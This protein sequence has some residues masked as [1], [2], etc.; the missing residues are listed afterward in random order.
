[1]QGLSAG[2]TF[3]DRFTLVRRLGGGGMG[4]VWLAEDSELAEPVALK[5]LDPALSASTG[6]V[7]L[8]RQECSRARSLVHPNIVRVFDF[9]AADE[10]FFVSMQYVGGN[11]LIASRGAAFQTIVHQV[12]MVCDALAY[13][14]RAGVI[15][16]DV[17]ASNVLVDPNGVCYLTD[18]G[19]ATVISPDGGA[20]GGAPQGGGTLPSMSP[21]QLAGQPAAVADDVYSL[22][23]LLYELLSGA[24][25]FHP[26]VT[27]EKIRAAKPAA[28]AADQTG[29]P[30]PES[31]S[32]L[33][34]AMLAKSPEQ[35]PA[36]IG[37]VRSVLEDV[38]ADFPPASLVGQD[39]DADASDVIRPISRR[40]ATPAV[41]GTDTGAP[42]RR[43]VED[44]GR[45]LPPALVYGSLAALLAVALVVI[46]LLPTAVEERREAARETAAEEPLETPAETR[47]AE[48][49]PVALSVKREIADE[50]L[51]ELLVAEDRL[52]AIG[53]DVWGA[54][55]WA[56][57]ER[58]TA[59]GDE[60]Y[61]SR[62]YA[63]AVNQYRQALNVMKILEPRA[64]E[65]LATALTEGVAALEAGDRA[66]AEQ[67]FELALAI[68]PVNQVAK[69]GLDRA[70][71]LDEILELMRRAAEVEGSGD[72]AAAAEL[73]EQA[74]AVD[75]EWSAAREGLRR[76][77]AGVAQLGYETR[78]AAGFGALSREEFDRAR[79]EFEAALAIRPG[80]ADAA[81]ALR[82]V[83]TEIRLAEV[84]RLQARARIAEA[85]EDWAQAVRHYEAILGIDPAVTSAQQNLERA[86]VRQ[87][88]SERLDTTIAK[89]DQFND[90]RVARAAHGLLQQARAV[91]S[92]GRVLEGQ[93][94]RLDELLRIAAIP[95]PV[96]FRSDNLT[97]V[98]IYKVGSLGT[99][100]SRTLDLKPGRYVAVGSRAGFRDVRRSFEVL[101]QGTGEPI[102]LSC[103][104]PI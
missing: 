61:Q 77:R 94:A 47:A 25:L 67:Q 92:P 21:Q 14:H 35:R 56:E 64:P 50:I 90:E 86:R 40:T 83:D 11:T 24:P 49:N 71:R 18:F 23:A 8:L 51:G 26:D 37:A 6:F 32:K 74:L 10:R 80:D 101:P 13:A 9:H 93:V 5:L 88:L 3:S 84:I 85:G 38:N 4:E 59:A 34:L 68:D 44:K 63:E 41:A 17:K 60:A 42:A 78:M 89:S 73:Y 96:V 69:T 52:R 27:P 102:E 87:Q 72:L 2:L 104:E 82:Q 91:S 103:E 46:F 45:T 55:D 48:P 95:V 1:M 54:A 79:R 98:V 97:E 28:L 70:L 76:S 43:R 62:A 36:G 19:L 15:H 58:L 100:Q 66:R 57:A 7:D 30:M 22:G 29:Q 20:D 65:I 31:L 12:L 33:V 99:F 39:A 16:R 53:V 81:A 75:P